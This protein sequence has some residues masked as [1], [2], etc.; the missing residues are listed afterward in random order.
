[1][2][3]LREILQRV[4]ANQGEKSPLA[5]ALR[6]QIMAEERGQSF[7]NLYLTGSVKRPV[8]APKK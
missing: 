1:M 3:T 5:Q 7:G 4:E 8:E 6:N 2:S